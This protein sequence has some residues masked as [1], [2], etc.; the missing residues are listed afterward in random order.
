MNS[1]PDG[2]IWKNI[3]KVKMNQLV[4]ITL[5]WTFYFERSVVYML[6]SERN[7]VWWRDLLSQLFERLSCRSGPVW[8]TQWIQGGPGLQMRPCL[9][10]KSKNMQ[11]WRDGSWLRACV[12][13]ARGP[14]F[15][16]P[17]SHW[18]ITTTYNS[19]PKGSDTV[20]WPPQTPGMPVAHIHA[21]KH[22]Q[23]K[24]C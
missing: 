16:S 23:I 8:T 6:L 7:W 4:Q 15:S 3:L 19:Y 24:N 10:I 11:C 9:K 1:R 5:L 17:H 12:L 21:G 20:F 14:R 18:Q 2:S 13:L 22:A